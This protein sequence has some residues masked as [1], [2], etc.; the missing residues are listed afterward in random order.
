[1]VPVRPSAR[2]LPAYGG[3]AGDARLVTEQRNQQLPGRYR[4]GGKTCRNT[5]VMETEEPDSMRRAI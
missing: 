2:Y 1:M 5:E 3:A 4:Q